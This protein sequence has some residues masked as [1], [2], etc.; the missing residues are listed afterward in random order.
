MK[1]FTEH[2]TAVESDNLPSFPKMPQR[3][4]LK[5]TVLMTHHHFKTL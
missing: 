3:Q 4:E 5:H 2:I 1:T